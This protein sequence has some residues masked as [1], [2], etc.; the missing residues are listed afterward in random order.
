M[1]K[2]ALIHGLNEDLAAEWGTIIRYTYQAGKAFGFVGV[3]LRE[4][5]AEEALDE[6]GHAAFLT[7]I[8]VDLGGEPTTTPKEFSKPEDLKAMLELDLEMEMQDVE[9]YRKHAGL[10]EELGLF[11]LQLKLEEMAVDEA[12]HARELRR[13]LKG[14]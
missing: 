9:N 7:D 4:W 13:I 6:M 2:E 12:G 5:F 10:A 3:E 8:I 1:S 11:E 14:L